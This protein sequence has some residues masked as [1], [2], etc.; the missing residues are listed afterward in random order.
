MLETGN[1]LN[2][3][4]DFQALRQE[5]LDLRQ[6]NDALRLRIERLENANL[7]QR[8]EEAPPARDETAPLRL[9]L[10][11]KTNLLF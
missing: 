8:N 5:N 2:I 7:R 11:G 6:E 1:I 9:V 10:R 3:L 4:R